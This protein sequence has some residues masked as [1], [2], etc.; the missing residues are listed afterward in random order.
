MFYLSGLVLLFLCLIFLTG[1]LF[2]SF[3]TQ[4]LTL[5]DKLRLIIHRAAM[6]YISIW[7]SRQQAAIDY[8][9]QRA[10]LELSIEQ[11]QLELR[12]NRQKLL[13]EKATD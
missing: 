2:L 10:K 6:D 8:E 5:L 13:S 9:R 12:K 11:G 3:T 4:F 1:W 7:S